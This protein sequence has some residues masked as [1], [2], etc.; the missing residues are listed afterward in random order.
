MKKEIWLPVLEF[1]GYEVSNKGNVRSLNYN[2][3]KKIKVLKPTFDHSKY[4][5]VG[6]TKN[7]KIFN[8]YVHRL[9]A[10]AFLKNTEN[11]PCIN[12]KNGIKIDNVVENLEWCTIA[13]NNRH[14]ISTLGRKVPPPFFK[15]K[16]G[17]DIPY[18]RPV[19]QIDKHTGEIL[20]VFECCAEAAE[21]TG[22]DNS[23]I[24]KAAKGIQKTAGK[25]KWQYI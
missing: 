10:I 14:C 4:L 25:F 21:K 19:N 2:R 6:L 24:G 20:A 5:K 23:S 1:D 3:E 8:R 18:S 16:R 13:E 7:K 17:K 11:K 22:I 15:G 9:V 12:H